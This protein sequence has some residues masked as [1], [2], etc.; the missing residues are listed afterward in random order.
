[1]A[2][3]GARWAF[4]AQY[5]GLTFD[6]YGDITDRGGRHQDTPGLAAIRLTRDT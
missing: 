2:V 5:Q 4:S 1:M 6:V 3:V